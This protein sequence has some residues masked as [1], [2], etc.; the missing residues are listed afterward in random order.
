MRENMDEDKAVDLRVEGPI[1]IVRMTREKKLNALNDA[2]ILQLMA[3]LQLLEKDGNIRGTIL[4]GSGRSFIVGADIDVMRDLDSHSARDF[5]TTLH[6]LIGMIRRSDKPVIAGINGYCFGAGLEVAISCDLCVAS[7]Q[8]TFGMQEVK[9]GVPSVI[10]AALL[11]FIVGLQKTR[12]LLLTG[13]T[14]DAA[15]AEKIG[16]VNRVVAPDELMD[17]CLKDTHRIVQNA[18]HAV[19]LQKKLINRWLEYA[20]LEQSV[21]TGIDYFGLSFAYPESR[22]VLSNALKK[23]GQ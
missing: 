10:E 17:A 13:E 6:E 1:A 20:G 2:M 4:T 7:S 15:V 11:P 19:T 14:I 21:K 3:A 18:M 12:E 5:I 8:A 23:G 16:L 22:D 9:V